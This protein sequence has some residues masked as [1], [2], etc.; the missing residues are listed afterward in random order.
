[1]KPWEVNPVSQKSEVASREMKM[2]TL[3]RFYWN[4]TRLLL[5]L[6]RRKRKRGK[7]RCLFPSSAILKTELKLNHSNPQAPSQK[8]NDHFCRCLITSCS[9]VEAPSEVAVYCQRARSQTQGVC[10]PSPKRTVSELKE[11]CF[12]P[13]LLLTRSSHPSNVP[14][15]MAPIEDFYEIMCV[16]W[17]V[18]GPR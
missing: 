16:T 17:N 11:V 1:M 4:Y 15:I 3:K 18:P 10:L 9:L 12:S 8:M 6:E 7:K 14:K 5:Y 2:L 13:F